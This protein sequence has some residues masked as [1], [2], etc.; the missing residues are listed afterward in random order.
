MILISSNNLKQVLNG[1]LL[2]FRAKHLRSFYFLITDEALWESFKSNYLPRWTVIFLDL[3]MLSSNI[4]QLES[5]DVSKKRVI[6]HVL[7]RLTVSK[8]IST[9]TRIKF[10]ILWSGLKNHF[11]VHINWKEHKLALKKNIDC[12]VAIFVA[13]FLLTFCS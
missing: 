11:L 6:V 5:P 3:T 1:V 13:I 12:K 10:K 2:N 9:A 4:P 7:S 8:I